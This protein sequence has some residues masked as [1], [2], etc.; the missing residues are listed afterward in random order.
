MELLNKTIIEFFKERVCATPE[1]TVIE[2]GDA[3]FTWRQLDDISDAL[4]INFINLGIK[5]STHVAICSFNNPN[6]VCCFLALQK[7]GSVALLVNPHLKEKEISDLI[8]KADIEYFCYGDGVKCNSHNR[9]IMKN[10]I[11]IGDFTDRFKEGYDKLSSEE[12]KKIEEL[13]DKIIANDTACIMFSSGTTSVPKGIMLSHHNIVN[14]SVS[15]VHAM[16]WTDKDKMFVAVPFYHSF[17]VSAC[18]VAS[19]YCGCR[20]VLMEKIKTVKVFESIE[21]NKCNILNGVPSMFLA[22]IH[23]PSHTQYNLSS[24]ESGIIAGSHIQKNDYIKICDTL[25]M[26][27][28]QMSYGLTEASPSVTFSDYW[29]CIEKKSDNVG[30]AIPGI[31]LVILNSNGI[32]T[33]KANDQGEI[34]VRGFNVMKGYYN[35]PEETEKA[36]DDEGWLHTGDMGYL[37]EKQVLHLI[38]RK[39]EIIIRCGENISP[40][41]IETFI[42]NYPGIIQTKAVGIKSEV[43][44]EE[45]VA[46]TILEENKN[47][48]K[49][50]FC[51][52]LENG[53][54]YYKI[55]KYVVEF[56]DFPMTSNG[57]IDLNRLNQMV[58]KNLNEGNIMEVKR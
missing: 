52:F 12:R 23:N 18:L 5:E 1:Q 56:N 34:L 53:L 11:Y 14:I 48:D 7:I 57:K 55:P 22:M 35:D 31:E 37:D 2:Y 42:L 58:Y 27:K 10:L 28:L 36:I 49:E 54:A 30:K 33:R 26:N 13:S 50:D 43:T 21:K 15:A 46:C 16:H 41:E 44:Q 17:G 8:A 19:I 20:M 9:M 51:K 29:D 32:K 3:S 25:N 24:L 39:K 47:L 38:G 4:A 6:W 45:I 40:F